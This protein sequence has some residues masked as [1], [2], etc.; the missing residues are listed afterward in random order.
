LTRPLASAFLLLVETELQR[1]RAPSART[2]GESVFLLRV[3]PDE[4]EPPRFEPG[5]F[6]RSGLPLDTPARDGSACCACG[7]EALLPLASAPGDPR[8]YELC[9][10]LVAS[11]RL[12][13]A[14]F[15][16]QPGAR[17]SSTTPAA[18]RF[19][20]SASSRRAIRARR[21]GDRNRALRLDAPR[22]R[23][24]GAGGA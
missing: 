7:C 12:T 2:S 13:P 8:G 9:L 17:L 18:G 20:S 4:A 1:D 21:D 24:Q 16:L 19:S 14:L 5:Q 22:V 11:G 10:A 15:R 23:G 6:V 3:R